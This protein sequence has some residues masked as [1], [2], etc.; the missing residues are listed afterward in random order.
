MAL[1]ALGGSVGMLGGCSLDSRRKGAV[2]TCIGMLRLVG[3]HNGRSITRPPALLLLRIA[4]YGLDVALVRPWRG[5]SL[6]GSSLSTCSA[7]VGRASTLY[8]AARRR[9]RSCTSAQLAS[10]CT[11]ARPAAAIPFSEEIWC[12]WG[13]R[14]RGSARARGAR[15]RARG[16]DPFD[17]GCAA[18]PRRFRRAVATSPRRRRRAARVGGPWNQCIEIQYYGVSTNPHFGA[19]GAF[20]HTYMLLP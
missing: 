16:R 1:L 13:G 10:Q 7:S 12:G 6:P 11:T 3:M 17:L 2:F 15:A 4:S 20:W 9:S 19:V 14:R 18:D 5:S 8:D